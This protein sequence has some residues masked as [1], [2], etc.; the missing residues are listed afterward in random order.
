MDLARCLFNFSS[1]LDEILEDFGV[2]PSELSQAQSHHQSSVQPKAKRRRHSPPPPRGDKKAFAL[3]ETPSLFVK[4]RWTH[5]GNT[6]KGYYRTSHGA[7]KGEIV[8]KGDKFQVIIK[9]APKKQLSTHP[10]H[11]CIDDVGK[12][13]VSVHLNKQ[14]KNNDVGAIVLYVETLIDESYRHYRKS[15][16]K[17]RLK[18][19]QDTLQFPEPNRSPFSTD[20]M[21]LIES[22]LSKHQKRKGGRNGLQFKYDP[23]TFPFDK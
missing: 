8:R 19:I 1:R 18:D 3:I 7:C 5:E 13:A 20:S 22:I 11:A 14:P 2:L 15:L 6:Y 12:N 16:G 17:E 10:H 21:D 4:R 9:D 23:F